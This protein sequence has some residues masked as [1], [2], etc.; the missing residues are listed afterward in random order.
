MEQNWTLI[1]HHTQKSKW[2]NDTNMTFYVFK[3]VK[4]LEENIEKLLDINLGNDIWGVTPKAQAT[5]I[6][7]NKWEYIKIKS[8]CTEKETTE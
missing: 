5:K 2:N 1:S 4:L 8:F 6:K 7:V 3:T